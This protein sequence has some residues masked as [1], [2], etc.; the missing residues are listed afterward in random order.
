M[1][2]P[3]KVSVVMCTY[4]GEKYLREQLDSIISQTYPIHEIIIQDD[5]STDGTWEILQ[6][7]AAEYPVIRIYRNEINLGVCLNFQSVIRKVSGYYIAISDQDDIWYPNKIEIYVQKIGKKLLA[8]SL[9]L[10][11]EGDKMTLTDRN[12][13][14][15]IERLIFGNVT[16]GHQMMLH[17]DMLKYIQD[18]KVEIVPDY[19]I[20]LIAYYFGSVVFI[21]EPL[22]IWRRHENSTTGHI[23]YVLKD[24]S[25]KKKVVYT[26]QKLFINKKSVKIREGFFKINQVLRMLN[27][28]SSKVNSKSIIKLTQLLSEQSF[29]GYLKASFL[30]YR[31]R[32][33][34]LKPK[35]GIYYSFSY[36]YRWWYD[37]QY[38][39]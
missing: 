13:N 26:M 17:R 10:R 11:K 25:G 4:N 18:V 12:T 20:A 31:L 1:N 16:S 19:L 29:L 23:N 3:I 8:V 37:H 30:I 24:I 27:T 5:C 28:D 35:V 15:P 39:M 6:E 38:D 36:I 7:Y 34:V 2:E 14:I 22:Q 21:D 33:L 9:S 32:D